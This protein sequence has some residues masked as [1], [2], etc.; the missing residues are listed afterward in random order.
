MVKA[1]LFDLDDT[2]YD[3]KTY[4]A[5]G[6]RSVARDLESEIGMPS[7]RLFGEMMSI[8]EADGRGRVFDLVLQRHGSYCKDRVLELVDL[9]RHH[10]PDIEPYPDVLPVL[11]ELQRNGYLLGLITNG[12][13][14]MQKKKVDALGVARHMDTLVYPDELG[15]NRWKPHPAGFLKGLDEL[16]V[17]P[18]KAMYVGNDAEKD[19]EPA[20]EAGMISVQMCRPGLNTVK[21]SKADLFVESTEEINAILKKK[22]E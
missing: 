16:A 6:F 3:E 18:E 4:V 10:Q 19:V 20:R 11:E 12:F 13:H 2:L 14:V 5:S 22:M 21:S 9:Y 17:S 7:D 1:I 8:L 15:S